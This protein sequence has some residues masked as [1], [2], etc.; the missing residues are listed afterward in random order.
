[1]P[2]L[3]ASA[4]AGASADAVRGVAPSSRYPA[5]A[6]L[7]SGRRPSGHGIVADRRM[8][9]HGVLA[10]RYSHASRLEAPTLWRAATQA[11]LGVASL[12]WPTTTGA[13]IPFNL[14]DVEPRLGE[15][16]WL[17]VL[18]AAT[19]PQVFRLVREA[20][21]DAAAAQRPGPAR[22]DVVLEVACRLVSGSGPPQ[23]L[24]AHLS[25]T[26]PAL[27]AYG[28]D[29]AETRAAFSAVD[30][31]LEQLHACVA[32]AGHL[33]QTSFVVVGDHGAMPVHTLVAPNTA[34]ARVGLL[35]LRQVG[36]E[37]VSWN[38][39]V[40]SNGGSAFVYARRREDA[41]LARRALEEA[42][43]RTGAFR[44]VS[45]EEML[46]LGADP[47]AWFGLEAEPGYAFADVAR[48][49]GLLA[50]VGRVGWGYL[51]DRPE[52]NSG[53]VAW[54]AGV[55]PR[56]RIPEMRQTD[57]APTVARLLG[58]QLEQAEG[59]TLVGVLRLPQVASPRP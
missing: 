1:M 57:V 43:A 59:R 36:S 8:G 50:A 27:L 15:E 24:L 19:T 14:P 13:E 12:S 17:G 5:H 22:D 29:A 55:R 44:I 2:F 38:A 18:A 58:L 37:L 48:G 39:L 21:G 16:T 26:D 28:V 23:L 47:D 4:A 34:L 51:P 46:R 32:E 20:G 56:I 53:F 11:G 30:A 25:Q 54:G 49:T 10:A 7:V 40:R 42:A 52:M 33:E 35:T 3:A 45:A 41:V 9:D 6:T 31:G